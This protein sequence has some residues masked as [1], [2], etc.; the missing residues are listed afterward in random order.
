MI[1]RYLLVLF[2]LSILTIAP[3]VL[4]QAPVDDPSPGDDGIA[5]FICIMYLCALTVPSIIMIILTFWVYSD[6]NKLGVENA[7]LWG[8]LVFLTGLVGLIIY[9]A[10]IRPKAIEDDKRKKSFASGTSMSSMDFP[11]KDGY[12]HH[13]GK[14]VGATVGRCT[15]CGSNL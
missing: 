11:R 6:A 12:C 13:C 9:L 4:A 5:G 7:W 2:F 8:L 10:V 15:Y 1:K 14:Y 3:V